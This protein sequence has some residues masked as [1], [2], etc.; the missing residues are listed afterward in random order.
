LCKQRPPDIRF[1][2]IAMNLDLFDPQDITL[3]DVQLGPS[4][5]VLRSFALPD[6]DVL[7]AGIHAISAIAPPRHMV[8]PGGH[9][10]SVAL[11]NCGQLGWTSNRYGYRYSSLNPDTRQSWPEMPEAFASL[12]HRAAHRAGFPDFYPDACLINRYE[13]GS[14]MGLHQDKNERDFDAPIVSVSLGIPAIFLFGGLS[15]TGPV[16]RVT[17]LHGDVAVWGGPDRLRYHGVAPLKPSVHPVLGML[18]LNLTFRRA[19]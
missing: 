5:V 7:L 15:R 3:P 17:L 12:A 6:A 14:R 16:Q 2:S 10:M 1:L 4:A 9:S 11:T 13:P 8:T 19:G 18:R